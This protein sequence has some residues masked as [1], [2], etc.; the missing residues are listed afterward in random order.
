MLSEY[1][2]EDKTCLIWSLNPCFSGI[3]SLSRHASGSKWTCHSLNPCFSGI[4][5]L[6]A[7][8]EKSSTCAVIVLILVLVEYA[9]WDV[10]WNSIFP[11]AGRVLILVLVEYALWANGYDA[12]IENMR[13]L[14]LV[15]VEYALWAFSNFYDSYNKDL[16]LVLVE[17]ALWDK[18]W[19]S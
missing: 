9:L 2:K 19:R 3:C 11:E 10:S 15:L 14:I 5:S 8:D 12:A 7:T 18:T 13:V 16:I 6:S 4:C 1:C 17:Y